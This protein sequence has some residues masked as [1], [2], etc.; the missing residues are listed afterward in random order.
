[1]AF[2]A[3][4]A[5]HVGFQMTV[6]VVVYP[7]LARVPA[8]QWV[9]AHRAHTRAITAVVALVYAGLALSGGWALLSG[10]DGWTLVALSATAVA[11]LVTA[12][13]AAPAHG[14]LSTGRDQALVVRLIRADRIR[15]VAAV[16][17]AVAAAIGSLTG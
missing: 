2:L 9:Q 14:R 6:T 13:V 17:A 16:T 4:A 10:P 7:A 11:V 1:M 12:I 8:G 5:A 3:A 15:A